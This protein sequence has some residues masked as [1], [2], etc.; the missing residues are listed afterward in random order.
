MGPNEKK[1][2]EITAN[3]L[4]NIS[5]SKLGKERKNQICAILIFAHL[6]IVL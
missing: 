4:F 2:M 3:D 6:N 1:G 5:M